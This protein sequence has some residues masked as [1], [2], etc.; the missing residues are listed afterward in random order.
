MS[1]QTDPVQKGSPAFVS[2]DGRLDAFRGLLLVSMT[3]N[4]APTRWAEFSASY[5]GYISSA[6][7][8]MFLAGLVAGIAYTRTAAR[9]GSSRVWHRGLLRARTIYFYHLTSF[10]V[11]Y[12]F[13]RVF[14]HG[15]NY[16]ETWSWLFDQPV[17]SAALKVAA[18][19]YQPKFLDILPMFV[20]FVLFTPF[21]VQQLRSGRGWIVLLVSGQ[22]WL[23]G[24]VGEG[25]MGTFEQWLG[26]MHIGVHFGNFDLLCWQLLY[27]T[28][29]YCGFLIHNG[30]RLPRLAIRVGAIVSGL[31]VAVFF[32]C[33]HGCAYLEGLAAALAP[34]ANKAMLG[35]VRVLNF[36]AVAFLLTAGYS[37]LKLDPL[38]RALAFLGRHSLQVFTFH[39]IVVS[40]MNV[41]M[42]RMP[43]YTE[44]YKPLLLFAAIASLFIPAWIHER[45]VGRVRQ[46]AVRPG[47][48]PCPS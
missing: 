40:V 15:E 13:L 21:L 43:D 36:A 39:V 12:V 19:L 10:V 45:A 41:F 48:A 22:L 7:G 6:E 42:P 25:L 28:G 1:S 3:I 32:L 8:F 9:D 23:L 27:M 47:V 4:H 24:Q 44:S 31:V 34:L 11:L 35:P 33:R 17:V 46:T 37:R 29:L 20:V 38:G 14:V 30:W 2:R 18:L 16:W 5:L 26:R